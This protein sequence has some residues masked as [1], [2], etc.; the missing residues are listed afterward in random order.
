MAV[1][2]R[3]TGLSSSFIIWKYQANILDFAENYKSASQMHYASQAWDLLRKANV[4]NGMNV[5]HVVF[6]TDETDEDWL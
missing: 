2:I 3:R 6:T 4:E 5:K 1:H